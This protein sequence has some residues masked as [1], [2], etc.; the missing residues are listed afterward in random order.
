M[1]RSGCGRVSVGGRSMVRKGVGCMWKEKNT[2]G[3]EVMG[4]RK[5]GMY[6]IVP[7]KDSILEELYQYQYEY[8]ASTLASISVVTSSLIHCY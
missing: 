7:A 1:G 4:R 2:W 5:A 3:R 6:I 8:Q